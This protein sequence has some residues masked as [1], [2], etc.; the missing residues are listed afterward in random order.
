MIFKLIMNL[1]YES[2]S[3]DESTIL[4]SKFK[5]VENLEKLNLSSSLNS[6]TLQESIKKKYS[7]LPFA[8][9]SVPYFQ[10]NKF[11][12][13][14]ITQGMLEEK[15]IFDYFIETESSHA[16]SRINLV[17]LIWSNSEKK[18]L[19]FILGSVLDSQEILG[20]YKS[21]EIVSGYNF[22]FR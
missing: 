1:R 8:L 9:L 17:G 5:I 21:N 11:K 15:S 6:N 13:F 22:M 4:P 14:L 10:H 12:H 2:V 3:G 19:D 18:E 20:M 7:S 16:D